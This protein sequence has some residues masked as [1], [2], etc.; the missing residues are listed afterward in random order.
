MAEKSE[1]SK[2]SFYEEFEQDFHHFPKYNVKIML[3]YFNAKMGRENIS[4]RHFGMG[5]YI[6]I[7]KIMIHKLLKPT[8]A[9]IGL[10]LF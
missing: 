8:N 6:R 7:V 10:V 3:R 9:L 2:D 1:D 5:I 4:K